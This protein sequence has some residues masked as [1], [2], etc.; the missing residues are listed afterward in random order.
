MIVVG[1]FQLKY[2]TLFR[3]VL[4]YSIHLSTLQVDHAAVCKAVLRRHRGEVIS[5]LAIRLQVV[6]GL[7][8]ILHTMLLV[9]SRNYDHV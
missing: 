6:P 5:Q 1:P 2:N 7:Q 4:F 3:S 9:M 8:T